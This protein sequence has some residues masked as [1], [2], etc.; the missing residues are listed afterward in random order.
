MRRCQVQVPLYTSQ[1]FTAIKHSCTKWSYNISNKWQNTKLS[2]SHAS[3][4]WPKPFVNN[5]H[6]L[7]YWHGYNMIEFK[8]RCQSPAVWET[9]RFQPPVEV[10]PKF[11]HWR[12]G[13]CPSILTSCELPGPS[14]VQCWTTLSAD[15]IETL[16]L[17]RQLSTIFFFIVIW[18]S[19]SDG[20]PGLQCCSFPFPF[21]FHHVS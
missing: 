11:W 9:G 2:I 8:Q 3:F 5:Y 12:S 13:S 15:Y 21:D 14:P 10:P 4:S 7:P 18:E 16:P 1:T 17:W 20:E 19:S 6:H